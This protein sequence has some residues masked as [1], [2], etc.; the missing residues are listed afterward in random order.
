M[1]RTVRIQ[2]NSRYE[3]DFVF[4][5]ND[6]ESMKKLNWEGDD[7]F[8][9]NGDMYDVIQKK[10]EGKKL[11]IRALA[12]KNE[13]DLLNKTSDSW[14]ENDKS[15]KIANELFQL[16]QTLFHNSTDEII[17]IKPFRFGNYCS[18]ETLPFWAKRI[19]TP[20]PQAF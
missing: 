20:P 19:L 1:K 11:I 2:E 13:T 14:K 7:E 9:L 5:M 4:S 12:D 16:L 3:T 8:S 15:N 17:I 6:Q 10:V 18:S